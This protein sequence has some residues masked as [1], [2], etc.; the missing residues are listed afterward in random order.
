MQA[1]TTK[2]FGPT[3]TRGARL[4]A[5]AEAGSITVGY[6]YALSGEQNHAA[7]AQAL[8]VK[9]GWSGTLVSGQTHTGDFVHVFKD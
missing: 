5:K 6:D 8:T 3:N 9:F 7:A 4:I 1:I 2:F